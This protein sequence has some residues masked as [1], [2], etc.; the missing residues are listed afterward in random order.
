LLRKE[1]LN[2]AESELAQLQAAAAAASLP[3]VNIELLLPNLAAEF[4]K[5][6]ERF[7]E[8]LE[9]GDVAK[10]REAIRSHVGNVTIE[11]DADEIRL[12]T[13]RNHIVAGLLRAAG[14]R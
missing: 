12:F 14:N 9:G 10:A 8:I 6:A 1:S 2:A 7:E 13:E 3:A 11:A 5:R 4:R